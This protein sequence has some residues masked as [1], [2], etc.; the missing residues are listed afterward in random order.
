MQKMKFLTEASLY[1][2]FAL[3]VSATFVSNYLTGFI[4][5]LSPVKQ[6]LLLSGVVLCFFAWG[7][8]RKKEV[9]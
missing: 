4:G 6:V 2:L 3:I 8:L 9:L 5:S 7:K 1:T